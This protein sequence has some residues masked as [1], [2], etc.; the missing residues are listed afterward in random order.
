MAEDNKRKRTLVKVGEKSSERY[1]SYGHKIEKPVSRPA[2]STSVPQKETRVSDRTP[3]KENETKQKI[4]KET[5][6]EPNKKTPDKQPSKTENKASQKKKLYSRIPTKELPPHERRIRER[7]PKRVKNISNIVKVALVLLLIA[8]VACLF[9]F[10]IGDK[11]NGIEQAFLSTGTIENVYNAKAQI[12]R[13]EHGV[14]AEFSGKLIAA[15]NDGDRVAAGAIVGYVVKPEFEE[16]LVSLRNTEDKINAAQNAASYVENQHTEFG[17]LN[18]EIANLTVVL[19]GM[20]SD[21]SDLSEY[22]SALRELNALFETKHEIMMNAESTDAYITSLKNE[23]EQIL[24]NL[25]NYMQEVK[26]SHAGVVSFYADNKAGEATQKVSQISEYI[27][28]KGETG[29]FISEFAL[30]FEASDLA[31]TV[32]ASVSAGQTVA[33]ITPDVTY[34]ITA[35]VTGLDYSVFK[36]GKQITVRAKT[37]D[38]SVEA[39]VEETLKFGDKTY[40][41][42]ESST[43]LVGSVSQRVID[44]ELVI[45]HMEGLKV[46]K[47][48]LSEWDSAGLTAR[49]AILRA[50]YVTYVYVNVLATDGEYAIISPSNGFADK[51]AEGITSV[52][53]ND[54]YIVN[55]E[56]VSDGQIIGG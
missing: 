25:Q 33:R 29:N 22:S 31:Y 13:E 39:K 14:N 12:I 44:A 19:S 5:A 54:I 48:A 23:R 35:D 51:E 34:Y 10:S 45:D 37:R 56:K 50:N 30:K 7:K 18:E 20:S 9:I 26:T 4:K 43:G 41:L 24:S 38:F 46:P 16:E 53:V 55:H 28:K 1:D 11:K 47:R 36:P 15:V 17:T 42:L 40:V 21:S 27:S 8:G 2:V 3:K 49:I 6:K 32:G 52:R